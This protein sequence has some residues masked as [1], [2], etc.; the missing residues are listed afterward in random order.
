MEANPRYAEAH[1]NL[2]VALMEA[3]RVEEAA[4]C[5]RRAVELKPDY[6]EAHNNLGNV[7]KEQGMLDEAAA[8]CRRAVALRPDFAVFHN[9]LGNVVK[10]QGELEDAAACYRRAIE[11]EPDYAEAHNNL[12]NV[13]KD[14]GLADEAIACYRRALDLKP[15]Y[16]A[17]HSNLLFAMQYRAGITPAALFEA[18]ADYDRRHAQF[19]DL[20]PSSFIPHPSSHSHL[21]LGFVSPDFGRHPVGYFLIRVLESVDR[22]EIETICYCDRRRKD[23]LTSRLQAATAQWRDTVGCSDR[24]L[25]EQI[26][27]DRIDILFDLAGHT[28]HNRLL[29]FGRRPAPIQMTWAGYVGTTGLAAMDYLLADRYEVPPGAERHYRE[30]V[31]RMP[32]GYVCYDPPAYAPP[33]GPLP[34]LQCEA[35]T[36]GCFNN[37]AKITPLAVEVWARVLRR[38]PCPVSC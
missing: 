19:P 11:L 35:V 18:H 3:G 29:V 25:A 34:A 37:P 14:Q 15:D 1:N 16:A 4:A 7:L 38:L 13:C 2:G 8:C 23:D 17:A 27:A 6:A 26:S 10:E 28:A 30:R 9:N 31:L 32:D 22:A 21:R 20:H 36:L 24:Q 33:V 12:G 5:C